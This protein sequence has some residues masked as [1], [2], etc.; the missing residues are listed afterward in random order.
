MSREEAHGGGDWGFSRCL[1]SPTAHVGGGEWAY[2]RT[3]REV[4][5]GDLVVHLRGK[6]PAA[7]FVGYSKA[8]TD[9]RETNDRPPDPGRWGYA[10][11][12]FRVDLTDYVPFVKPVLLDDVF[13]RKA[14]EL[15]AYVDRWRPAKVSG[16]KR[17]FYVW[18][19]GRLQCLNGA[20]LSELDEELA[21]I[22]FATPSFDVEDRKTGVERTVQTSEQLREVRSR[23]GQ[24]AFSAEVRK[25]YGFQCC[26]PSCDVT[27]HKFLVGAHIARWSDV[28]ELRGDVGNG[29]CLCLMHD[30]AFELGLFTLDA[31]GV[32]HVNEALA[33]A[34]KWATS[35]LASSGGSKIS[36][37]GTQLSQVALQSHWR[38]I[39]F[40]PKS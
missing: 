3:M 8:A 18:Q 29:L 28:P 39:G 38:R 6:R 31:A 2:W 19:N 26:F 30:R 11:R 34:S 40:G 35:K 13:G 10:E 22:L 21:E 37:G 23:V 7:Y 5:V 14:T 15:R 1:W 36:Q 17:L 9:C 4:R 12:F 25:N 27:D 32:V 16:G 20:Y 33:S 24:G